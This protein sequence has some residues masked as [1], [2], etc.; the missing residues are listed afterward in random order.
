MSGGYWLI[1]HLFSIQVYC[2]LMILQVFIT[3]AFR[4]RFDASHFFSWILH[5][6]RC[7]LNAPNFCLEL[8]EFWLLQLEYLLGQ[9]WYDGEGYNE[10][11][12]MEKGRLVRIWLFNLLWNAVCRQA[13]LIGGIYHTETIICNFALKKMQEES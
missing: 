12:H 8:V 2:V 11:K 7:L 6:R 5:K 3:D 13:I 4:F 1:D 9:L 10:G